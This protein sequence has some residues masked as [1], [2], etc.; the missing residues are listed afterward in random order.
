MNKPLLGQQQI[1]V[2]QKIVDG[3]ALHERPEYKG[4]RVTGVVQ[5]EMFRVDLYLDGTY[6][7]TE[8]GLFAAYI[9]RGKIPDA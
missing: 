8:T 6:A 9:I 3:L 1:D 5:T 2:A 7:G 4:K